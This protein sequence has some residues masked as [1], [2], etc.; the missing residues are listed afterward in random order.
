[1][2]KWRNDDGDELTASAHMLVDCTAMQDA[3]R[4][5]CIGGFAWISIAERM[6]PT[7]AEVLVWC[8]YPGE[9]GWPAVNLAE[10]HSISG[11]WR[12]LF[13]AE[14]VTHWMPLPD[15]PMG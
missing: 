12:G 15:P 7:R 4:Q 5:W 3:R 8:V 10:W 6:P 9:A 13:G 1:M 11:K 2:S 14:A